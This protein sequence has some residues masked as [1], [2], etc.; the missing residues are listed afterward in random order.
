[1]PSLFV[2]PTMICLVA[3]S[4]VPLGLCREWAGLPIAEC[5]LARQLPALPAVA[6]PFCAKLPPLPLPDLP[7][8]AS[9]AQ[10]VRGSCAEVALRRLA[11]LSF[12]WLPWPEMATVVLGQVSPLP[13]A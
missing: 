4:G 1:M 11:T 2:T 5:M 13:A 7:A 10:L 9:L 6:T 3:L 12:R 8:K